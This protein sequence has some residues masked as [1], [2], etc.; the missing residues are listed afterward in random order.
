[1]EIILREDV[2]KLG[3]KNDIVT[4]KNGY[5][6]NYLIPQGKAVLATVSAKKVLAENL[7]QQAHKEA[8]VKE[9]AEALAAKIAKVTIKIGAKAG[10]NGKIFGSINSIQLAD[11]FKAQGLEVERKRISLKE[12]SVKTLG[13]YT[14]TARLHKEVSQE[15]TFEVIAE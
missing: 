13:S 2:E 7:K 12:D 3:F 15:F 5:G 9:E 10:E 8:K 14:A 11:A 4:V 6:L 1:M